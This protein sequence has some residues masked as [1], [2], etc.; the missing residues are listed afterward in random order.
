M[1]RSTVLYTCNNSGFH[2]VDHAVKFGLVVY[3]WSNAKALWANARPMSSEELLTKQCEAVLAADP[4]VPGEQP[5]CWVYRNTIKALNWYSSVREKLD[6]PRYSSWFVKFKG[7]GAGG[8]YRD[9]C[10][11]CGKSFA[12]PVALVEHVQRVHE[13][14]AGGGSPSGSCVSM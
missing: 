11:Q 1:M 13:G 6:D 9:V 4:G 10:P 7:F 2:N 14:R 12:S 3:D 5:R 8:G